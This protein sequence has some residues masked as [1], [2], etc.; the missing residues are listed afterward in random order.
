MKSAQKFR[1]SA[2]GLSVLLCSIALPTALS[3]ATWADEGPT[4]R[5]EQPSTTTERTSPSPPPV[6]PGQSGYYFVFQNNCH[7]PIRLALR[8]LDSTSDEWVTGGWWNFDP[9]ESASLM[10]GDQYVRSTNSI[11]YYYAEITTN[12]YNVS[13]HGTHERV[14]GGRTLPMRRRE[15]SARDGSFQLP[16]QCDDID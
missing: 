11:F 10:H 12:G 2:L 13:W 15:M 16:I 14:L 4:G 3:S 7:H 6:S 9:N 5:R 8:Y 1:L